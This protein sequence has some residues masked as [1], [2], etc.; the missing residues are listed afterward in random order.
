MTRRYKGRTSFYWI[1]AG[2]YVRAGFPIKCERIK[3][4]FEAAA[5]RARLLNQQLDSWR[6]AQGTPVEFREVRGV[7]SVDWF[8]DQFIRS[9]IFQRKKPR[10]QKDYRRALAM[11]ADLPTTVTD[12][13]GKPGRIGDLP[14]SS[15]SHAAVDKIYARL[16]RGGEVS[17]QADM[18]IDVARRAWGVVSR[19]HP[20]Y[21]LIPIVGAGGAIQRLPV[22]PFES[23]ERAKYE[24]DTA[25]PATRE[26]AYA[27]AD[28]LEALGHPALAVG[29]LICF[30]WLQR[31][32][33]VRK[34]RLTWTDYR[35]ATRPG[36]VMVWHHKT[37][38]RVWTPLEA[39][40]DAGVVKL[41][42]EI[43]ERLAKL[44]RLGTPI[45]LFEPQRGA[46]SARTPRTYSE[47][48]AQHL[49]QQARKA[50]GLPA[51]ITLEA[52]RHGGMTEL[53][54]LG[55]TEQETMSLSGHVT[56]RAARIYVKRT[57]TQRLAA[58]VKRRQGIEG[59]KA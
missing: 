37:G 22:N 29:A 49:V 8:V 59:R 5:Q 3:G 1:P 34:G 18:S 10:T 42:P 17:R 6:E 45:V 54:D 14:V 21:F 13:A 26:E 32:D 55:L 53:G 33:D 56:P 35:P 9:E 48:Y 36:H 43:E 27:L 58:A 7:G 12:A 57:E 38:A 51:H 11:I 47:P 15:L 23:V 20:G 46:P 40:T 52:C 44:P 19:V 50:A 30:E 39:E 16:R 28:A 31:P 25:T 41:Y 24:R 2:E 4:D